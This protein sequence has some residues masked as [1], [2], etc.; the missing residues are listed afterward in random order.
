MENL[1]N[2]NTLFRF[3]SLRA[4]DL[5]ERKGK[6][7]RF[8]LDGNLNASQFYDAVSNR[9]ANTNKWQAMVTAATSYT[10]FSTI[11]EVISLITDDF[12]TVAV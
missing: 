3:I 8:V 2:Q 12:Y 4:P 1:K 9:P 11:D 5:L 6:N 10:P 7:N